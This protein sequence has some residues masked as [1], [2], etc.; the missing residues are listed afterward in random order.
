MATREANLRIAPVLS[1]VGQLVAP[2]AEVTAAGRSAANRLMHLPHNCLPTAV[3]RQ[4][5]AIGMVQPRLVDNAAWAA[6]AAARKRLEPVWSYGVQL[7]RLA[8][9]EGAT[10]AQMHCRRPEPR[11]WAAPAFAY[12]LEAPFVE[13]PPEV[14]ACAPAVADPSASVDTPSPPA[15]IYDAIREATC[16]ER[17]AQAL[18]RRADFIARLDG[19]GKAVTSAQVVR[20]MERVQRCSPAHGMAL[21]RTWLG[22]WATS[23][24]TQ[25][26]WRP[27]PFGC[28]AP[29]AHDVLAHLLGCPALWGEVAAVVGI[30]EAPTFT[31]RAGLVCTDAIRADRGRHVAPPA[32]VLMLTL[33]ADVYHRARLR[34]PRALAGAAA[35]AVARLEH[36]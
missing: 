11:G 14:V 35:D 28:F 32:N 3:W 17:A 12:T 15:G 26:G 9:M 23:H 34:G 31:L 19:E 8:A 13:A 2:T 30:A 27:C 4:L 1:Y 24:R 18:A 16:I 36:L 6:L 7:L 10:L 25:R 5:D 21:L 20:V 29:A 22:G 33:A